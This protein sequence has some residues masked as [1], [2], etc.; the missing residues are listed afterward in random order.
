MEYEKGTNVSAVVIQNRQ[1]VR[2]VLAPAAMLPICSNHLHSTASRNSLETYGHQ[3][4]KSRQLV[5]SLLDAV[6]TRVVS[7]AIT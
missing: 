2:P 1:A 5:G 6:A 4:E 3:S 7:N